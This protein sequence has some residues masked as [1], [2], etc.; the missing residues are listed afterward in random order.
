MPEDF[1]GEEIENENGEQQVISRAPLPRGKEII[2][3]IE[4]RLGGNKMLV[5]C[6]DGK[7]RNC[8]VPGRLKRKLWLRPGDVVIVEPWEL[9]NEKGDIILKYKPN[10]IEWLKRKGYLKTEKSEF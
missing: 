1:D 6:S 9:D 4:Q 7:T 10:Q 2:G 5:S 8:R 3:T